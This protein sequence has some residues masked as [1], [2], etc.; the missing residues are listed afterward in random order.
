VAL[1]LCFFVFSYI[2]WWNWKNLRTP[3]YSADHC[4]GW[5]WIFQADDVYVET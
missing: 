2:M 1:K 3:S 4:C 5:E